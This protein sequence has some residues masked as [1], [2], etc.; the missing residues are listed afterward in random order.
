[1]VGFNL[2]EDCLR[3]RRYAPESS[4]YIT[5]SLFRPYAELGSLARLRP[6]AIPV[7]AG[8]SRKSVHL[9]RRRSYFPKAFTGPKKTTSRERLPNLSLRREPYAI[10]PPGS[11]KTRITGRHRPSLTN[12]HPHLLIDLPEPYEPCT[13]CRL[14]SATR[15]RQKVA[16]RRPVSRRRQHAPRATGAHSQ[17]AMAPFL[18]LRRTTTPH[19]W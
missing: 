3:L 17:A 7:S 6:T 18:P 4:F 19:H 11:D 16:W 15:Q 2:F 9:F 10:Q 8:V 14:S 1:M 12:H 13:P 5:L